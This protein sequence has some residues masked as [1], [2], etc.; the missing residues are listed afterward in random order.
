MKP[1]LGAALA[2]ALV[3]PVLSQTLTP[4]QLRG[5]AIYTAGSSVSAIVG[6][7]VLPAR[8]FP[9]ASCHGEDGRGQREGGTGIAD[10][11]PATLARAATLQERRRAAYT[12][13][14]L[15]LAITAGKDSSGQPLDRAMPRYR[16]NDRDAADLLAY[17]AI[18]DNVMPS[19][20]TSDEVRINVIAASGLTA[21]AQAIYG[22][23]IVLQYG[24]PEGALLSIDEQIA[25][26][27]QKQLDLVAATLARVGR[28]FT[29]KRYMEAYEQA[30]RLS[31]RDPQARPW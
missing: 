24:Q 21:P 14:L 22:R 9:C 26:P 3:S 16:L 15:R 4:Q 8:L 13:A 29:R 5:Q 11:T 2:L 28:D 1:L 6:G 19:G 23:R 27:A 20:V 30:I 7:K 25:A 17:L 31:T 12:P 18:L 10:I